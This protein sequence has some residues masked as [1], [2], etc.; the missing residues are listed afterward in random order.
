MTGA[1]RRFSGWTGDPQEGNVLTVRHLLHVYKS[2]LPGRRGA[3]HGILAGK[4][5]R[6]L[7]RV[8]QPFQEP[9]PPSVQEAAPGRRLHLLM[10]AKG[11][12]IA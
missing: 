6:P 11:P 1:Y 4:A 8:T 10:R 2:L 12:D 3:C 5:A 9:Y 7:G